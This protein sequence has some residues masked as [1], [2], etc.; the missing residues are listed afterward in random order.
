VIGRNTVPAEPTLKDFLSLAM[1][2]AYLAG[3][4]TLAY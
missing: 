4:R 2:A 3:R 1:D